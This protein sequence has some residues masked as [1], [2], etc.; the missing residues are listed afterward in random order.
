MLA[1]SL[2]YRGL[3]VAQCHDVV[4]GFIINRNID[5]V[6]IETDAVE[7]VC[8]LVDRMLSAGGELVTV[9]FGDEYGEAATE[10]VLSRLRSAH[11]DI[12]VV[13]EAGDG[14]AIAPVEGAQRLGRQGGGHEAPF[15]ETGAQV[16]LRGDDGRMAG[17]S[18]RKS[19]RVALSIIASTSSNIAGPA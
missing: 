17:S 11:P 16:S 15:D 14:G 6:V 4:T 7:A 3:N 5:Q 8:A 13:G 2:N 19:A 10:S 18:C 9:L 12:E 1:I